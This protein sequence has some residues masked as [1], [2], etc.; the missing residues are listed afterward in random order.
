[1]TFKELAELKLKDF[2]EGIWVHFKNNID[3]YR[4]YNEKY[5][6]DTYLEDLDLDK[7]FEWNTIAKKYLELYNKILQK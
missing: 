7:D 1:M 2:P 4:Y 6:D 3:D 5:L